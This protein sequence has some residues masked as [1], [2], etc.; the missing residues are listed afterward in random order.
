MIEK[1]LGIIIGIILIGV[2]IKDVI[3]QQ[4]YVRGGFTYGASAVIWG[5]LMIIGGLFFILASCNSKLRKIADDM[6][7]GGPPLA[8]GF[9]WF[10]SSVLLLSAVIL[11]ISSFMKEEKDI[12]L[13]VIVLMFSM[14][15][16]FIGVGLR[17]KN[18]VAGIIG[19]VISVTFL[20]IPL[21]STLLFNKTLKITLP[22]ILPLLIIISILI[23]WRELG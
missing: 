22:P 7:S 23:V 11:V 3:T 10:V 20:I 14:I 2:G 16:F 8:F 4:A 9:A 17:K 19:I 21:L 5:S 13:A 18:R 1:I 6:R 15:Y 12:M